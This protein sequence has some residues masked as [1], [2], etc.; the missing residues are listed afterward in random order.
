M[1]KPSV[2]AESLRAEIAPTLLS[3]VPT[4]QSTARSDSGR[5]TPHSQLDLLALSAGIDF[6]GR[7]EAEKKK[8]ER[9]NS[10]ARLL[11]DVDPTSFV[12]VCELSIASLVVHAWI[13]FSETER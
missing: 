10:E 7:K 4:F 9:K 1:D 3:L 8:Q 2:A 11:D 12:A 13:I 5:V 6:L